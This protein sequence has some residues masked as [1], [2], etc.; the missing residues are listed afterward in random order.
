MKPLFSIAV[1]LLVAPQAALAQTAA[2]TVPA[3]GTTL[4]GAAKPATGAAAPATGAAAPKLVQRG[5]GDV[6]PPEH[7]ATPEQIKEYLQLTKS[8]E[9]A[10]RAFAQM[11]GNSRS[12]AP[13]YF[14]ADFWT[15]VDQKFNAID[16]G[17]E[18]VPIYQRYFSQEDMAAALAFYK[19]P[20]GQRVLNEQPL[21]AVA[22]SDVLRKDGQR[23]GQ[24]ALARHKDEIDAAQ[25]AAQGGAAA[26]G[27]AP[28]KPTLSSP[29]DK[30][31]ASPNQ[32]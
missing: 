1:A 14:P 26:P 4:P 28:A 5:P 24:E 8:V 23:V 9:N 21:A 29:G 13:A 31:A 18:L 6:P 15:D 19:T 10:H 32:K 27:A 17:S 20:A 2:T 30:P 22:S 12:Q 25:K 16:I 11:V 3:P 7:P